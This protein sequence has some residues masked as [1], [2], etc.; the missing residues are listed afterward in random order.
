M[1]LLWTISGKDSK[2]SY[3]RKS[4][5]TLTKKRYTTTKKTTSKKST[6]KKSTSRKSTSSK[7]STPS[8][9]AR[10]VKD[11]P[12]WKGDPNDK[13]AIAE[14]RRSYEP[15]YIPKIISPRDK[16][17][18]YT[19]DPSKTVGYITMD[20]ETHAKEIA[21]AL[22]NEPNVP[23]SIVDYLT[24]TLSNVK[25]GMVEAAPVA[26]T[27]TKTKGEEQ[28]GRNLT[29]VTPGKLAAVVVALFVVI[30]GVLY[31]DSTK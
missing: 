6:S 13:V 7:K 3:T 5:S 24:K 20:K 17:G 26:T 18:K 9:V 8:T 2:G 1:F 31:L 25:K 27:L 30:F 12:T 21:I 16:N 28:K 29:D 22:Q 11:L 10:N 15:G 19:S 4:G 14:W 23:T